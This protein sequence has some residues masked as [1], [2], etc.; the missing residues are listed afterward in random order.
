V[1]SSVL[2]LIMSS[3]GLTAHKSTTTQIKEKTVHNN[4]ENKTLYL[5]MEVHQHHG[6]F[7]TGLVDGVF[8]IPIH[9]I[10]D[11]ALIRDET[12]TVL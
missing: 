5:Q 10:K 7:V 12:Q 6:C 3:E 8:H 9:N 11:L 4:R 1:R 2:I